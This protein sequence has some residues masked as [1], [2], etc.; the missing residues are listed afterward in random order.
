[1]LNQQ[2][3]DGQQGSKKKRNQHRYTFKAFI[4]S[5]GFKFAIWQT[6][7]TETTMDLMAISV[8]E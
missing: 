3:C 2:I 4:A 7:I 5:S 1:M 6:A 8:A